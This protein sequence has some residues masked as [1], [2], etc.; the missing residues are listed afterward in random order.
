[1]NSSPLFLSSLPRAV[2]KGL[3]LCFCLLALLLGGSPLAAYTAMVDT[4]SLSVTV[5]TDAN[6]EVRLQ[7]WSAGTIR[8]EAVPK[9]TIPEKKSLA[10]IATA[11]ATGWTV[12]KNDDTVQLKSTRLIAIVDKKSGLVSFTDASGKLLLKQSAWSFQPADDPARDGLKLSATFQRAAGEHFYGGGVI[13]DLRQPTASIQL[14]NN[15]TQIRIPI[16]YSSLGY[17]VFWDNTSRGHLDLTPDTVT[18]NASA[19]DLADFYIMAGPTA[20][21]AIAE[22]RHLTGAAPMFPEW[23]YGFWFCKNKF[24]SQQEILDAAKAFRDHQF[25]VDLIVQDYFYWKPNKSTNDWAGWGSHHFAEERYPDP[26]A[27]ITQ[28]HD[29][30]HFH[31]M[32]VIWPKFDDATDHAEELDAAHALFPHPGT[33][34]EGAG[35]RFYDPFSQ[36][37][38][39]IYDRQVMESLLPLGVDAFWMDAAEPEIGN[40]TFAKF[41]STTG[42]MSRLMDAFPLMHTEGIYTAQRKVSDQKRVVLLPRSSWAGEQR[43]GAANWTGDIHQDWKTLAWQIE[44]L[45]NYS[46]AGL[47][48]ITT[49]VGGYGA[50]P[51][52][53]SDKALFIRWFQW[54]TFCPIYRVHGIGRPFPWQYGDDALAIMKKFDLIRYRLLPYIYT[55]GARI[56]QESGTL[57]RPLVMDF[58]DDPQALD[59]WDEF[60]FGPS[61]LV[62]PVYKNS[63]ESIGTVAQWADQDGKPGG[64]TATFL[65][66][67]NE[68]GSHVDLQMLDV[69]FLFKPELTPEQ[70]AAKSVRIEGTFTPEADGKLE[71]EFATNNPPQTITVDGQPVNPDVPGA[72]FVFAEF[73]LNGKA[74]VPLHLS[75][76]SKDRRPG[77]RI[78]RVVAGPEHRDVYLPGKGDWYDFWTGERTTG[79]QTLTVETPIERIPLYLRAGSIVPMGPELQYAAE[80]PAD[81]IELR[82]YRG[83]DGAF[84]LYSDENDNYD[85]EKG[86]FSH[87]P[88][89]WSE[90]TQT[91]TIGDQTGSFPGMLAKRMFHIVW[92]RKNHG[93]GEEVVDKADAD[94]SYEGHAVTV[95]APPASSN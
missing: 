46:I 64:I 3:P 38:R 44:G 19:G 39:D 93:A 30:Y 61:L 36:T 54:G 29:D 78:R 82:V 20:D 41:D 88:I 48:Y 80:K 63:A 56:T 11:D 22:Y 2:R 92:V 17:S 4:N 40:G 95:K 73:P 7:P 6:T 52:S 84:S 16:L 31:F 25:P 86:A 94:V 45:Q 15:N 59:T 62:C 76:E 8:V 87:I 77:F 90:A 85:Y 23:A 24:N 68:A 33:T 1:M 13:D 55:Q 58:Q 71:L 32:T 27:M 65:T 51:V 21:Q 26:K 28:L 67:G 10:V 53:E 91:L 9:G 79:G 35:V 5:E 69:G 66:N 43:N 49:D 14:V 70:R 18:W 47:P 89:T 12:E 57:M 42:P 83:A 50:G 60:L 81:P 74:G 37:G 34:G 72:N 75:F